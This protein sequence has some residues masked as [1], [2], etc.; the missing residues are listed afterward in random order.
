MSKDGLNFTRAED[1]QIESHLHWLGGAHSD[2]KVITF[3]GTCDV[4]RPKNPGARPRRA[5][6]W[7]A[8]SKDSRTWK[9]LQAPAVLVADPGIVAARDGGWVVVGTGPQ[10]RGARPPREDRSSGDRP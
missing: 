8:R 1:V 9:I 3:I 2:G 7:I 5:G 4:G 6:A 10:R